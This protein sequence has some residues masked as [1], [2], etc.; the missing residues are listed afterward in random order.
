MTFNIE[1]T[2]SELQELHLMLSLRKVQ[3][4]DDLKNKNKAIVDITIRQ[5][6]RIIPL[7]YYFESI[8]REHN[9]VA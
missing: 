2:E 9:Q 3:L 5:I 4:L 8:I 1:L 6:E 7:H